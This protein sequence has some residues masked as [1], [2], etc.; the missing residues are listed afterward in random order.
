MSVYKN[1]ER[2][3]WYTIFRYTDWTGQRKQKKKEGFALKREAQEYEREYIKKYSGSCEMTFRSM[4]DLYLED[5][6]NHL[7]PT[8]YKVK[9]NI[10]DNQVLPF[11]GDIPINE[12]TPNTLRQFNN[13]LLENGKDYSTLYLNKVN[14]QISCVF[15]FAVKYYNLTSN[16]CKIY[17]KP[18]GVKKTDIQF[19]TLQEFKQFIQ[20]VERIDYKT[21]YEVL[22]WTGMRNG[23]MLALTVGD[24]DFKNNLISI[25]KNYAKLDNEELILT[26]KTKKSKRIVEIP[27]F[28]TDH[29]KEYLTHVYD[30]SDDTRLFSMSRPSL[31]IHLNE[32]AE[33]AGVK[34]I[35]LHDLRHS[36]ASL[37]IELGF[38]PL[39]V[40]D[41]LGHE[42]VK[43]TLET[44]SHLYPHKQSTV[45]EKL[46]TLI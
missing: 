35:R 21:A 34:K 41:R 43:T 11:L 26:P 19:W 8:S 12:I 24:I 16:P 9:K 25:D 31:R 23:E 33:K 29:I 17:S 32:V 36:H 13:Q 40:A 20:E 37:L 15:T 45:C 42:N 28:L 22:F 30:Y 27:R 2:G 10:L 38:Q 14:G 18:S 3:T 5:A 4:C 6:K 39:I 44:Y 7:K 46:E 1:E